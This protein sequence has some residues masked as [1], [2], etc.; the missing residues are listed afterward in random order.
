MCVCVYV[1][2]RVSIL[3]LVPSSTAATVLLSEN[4]SYSYEYTTVMWCDGDDLINGRAERGRQ[5]G[6]ELS[7]AKTRLAAGRRRY[8][9]QHQRTEPTARSQRH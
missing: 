5:R 7:A 3:L 2:A 6:Q 9:P 1:R 8:I 4:K